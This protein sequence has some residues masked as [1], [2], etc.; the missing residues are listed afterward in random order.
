MLRP[1]RGDMRHSAGFTLIE[2]MV[3]AVI[4][5]TVLALAGSMLISLST[6]TNRGNGQV[7]AQQAVS[8]AMSRLSSDLRSAQK[9]VPLGSGYS[10]EIEIVKNDPSGGTTPVEWKYSAT[11]HTLTRSVLDSAGAVVSSEVV[12][13]DVANTAS[14]PVLSYFNQYGGSLTGATATTVAGCATRVDVNLVG[15]VPAGVEPFQERVDVALTNQLETIQSE[16]TC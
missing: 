7:V 3:A 13:S 8:A 11:Q 9:L 2:L 10:S 1:W 15:G 4:S 16:G 12:L 6:G 14:Q 5:V